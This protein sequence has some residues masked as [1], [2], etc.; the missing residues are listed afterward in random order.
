MFGFGRD[1][2]GEKRG[3]MADAPTQNGRIGKLAT[4]LGKDKLCLTRFEGTEAIG[5]LFEYRI[6]AVSPDAKPQ[7]QRPRS[8][9]PA[10][11]TW[12]RPIAWG[13]TSAGF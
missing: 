6:E 11:S 3:T 10:A 5:E 7:F 13:A 9:K 1:A 2:E 4:P 8:E 12:K